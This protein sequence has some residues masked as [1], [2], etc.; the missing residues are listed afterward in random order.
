MVTVDEWAEIRRL[1]RSERMPIKA[2]ARMLGMSK[3]TVRRAIRGAAVPRY[4]RA[5]AGS[6]VDAHEAAI[7]E[8]LKLC[9]TMPATVIAERIGWDNSITVLRDRVR[10]LRPAYLPLDPT[11]RT[12]YEPGELAQCDLWFPPVTLPGLAEVPPVLVMVSGYSRWILGRMIPSRHAE[13][14]VLAHWALLGELGATPRALV[15]DNEGG[16]GKYQRHRPPKLSAEFNA[17]RGLLGIKVIVLPPREPESKGIVERANEY[18]ETSFVPGRSFTGPADFNAQLADW[19]DRANQ[20][21]RRHLECAP[22]DR[23]A[24]DRSAMLA[25]PPIEVGSLGWH[26]S[27]I[28]PRDHW[29]RIDTCDYSVD[30][31]VIG[32]RVQV[33]ADLERVR[34]RCQGRLVADH[35]RSWRPHQTVTDPVHKAEADRLRAEHLRAKLDAKAGG[36]T[37]REVEVEQ[38]PLWVYDQLTDQEVA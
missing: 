27:V 14:L 15:W 11:S 3:N 37:A 1:Y 13:D 28:L 8:Q 19:L 17:L 35:P 9:P 12:S 10:L 33:H 22:A 16:I 24:G 31:T 34:V 20:R 29:V 21:W 18:L 36:T 7:R 30:P 23:I 25:L 2:I 26:A 32:R 6:I 38:R 4:E 5:P